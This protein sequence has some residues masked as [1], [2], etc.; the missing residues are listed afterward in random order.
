VHFNDLADLYCVVL[1]RA[2][3]DTIVHAAS[4]N[5]LM[6]QVAVAIHR[7]FGFK[8][9]PSSLTLSEARRFSPIADSL[10]RSHAL[11][12][13]LAKHLLGWKPRGDSILKEVERAGLLEEYASRHKL[14]RT[15]CK[16]R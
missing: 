14:P 8:G 4:E 6:K 5:V 10:V 2:D 7:G 3:G 9:E 16:E 15:E 1:K 12:G 11:S 13:D